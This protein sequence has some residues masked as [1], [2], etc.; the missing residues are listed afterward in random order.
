MNLKTKQRELKLK[1][2]EANV[3]IKDLESLISSKSIT[4]SD[5]VV[6]NIYNSS[7][8]SSTKILIIPYG[9]AGR[10]NEQ[11]FSIAG[12]DGTLSP[13]SNMQGVTAEELAD[14]LDT[15]FPVLFGKLTLNGLEEV[16]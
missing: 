9:W 8:N 16:K 14:Y 13:Y 6:G 11:L 4:S 3:I 7:S 10:V 1:V 2:A 5:I 15:E 12:L